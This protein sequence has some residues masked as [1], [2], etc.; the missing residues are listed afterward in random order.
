VSF[1]LLIAF[2]L[3]I[4]AA[5]VFGPPPPNVKVLAWSGLGLWLLI[6]WAWWAER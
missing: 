1:W 6:P 2:L 4:Y 3:L 5:A